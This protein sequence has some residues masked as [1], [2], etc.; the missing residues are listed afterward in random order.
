MPTTTRRHTLTLAGLE[1]PVV[2]VTGGG[3]GPRLVVLLVLRADQLPPEA[4]KLLAGC[5]GRCDGR[6]HRASS[7]SRFPGASDEHGTSP[8]VPCP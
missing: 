8:L 4:L 5:V 6:A 3:D 2:E 1:V 7:P